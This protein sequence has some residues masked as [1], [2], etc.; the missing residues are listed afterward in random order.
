ML[1]FQM[2]TDSCPRCFICKDLG[3]EQNK[4]QVSRPLQTIWDT[5]KILAPAFAR[6]NLGHCGHVGD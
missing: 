2:S 6:P 4:D 1:V 3:E 5:Q